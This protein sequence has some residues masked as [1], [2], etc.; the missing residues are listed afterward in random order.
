[1][2]NERKILESFALL[3]CKY[4]IHRLLGNDDSDSSFY[5][6]GMYLLDRPLLSYHY[7]SSYRILS[8]KEPDVCGSCY[9]Y[10]GH[11]YGGRYRMGCHMCYDEDLADKRLFSFIRLAGFDVRQGQNYLIGIIHKYLQ[12]EDM[13]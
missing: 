5:D 2:A 7:L 1:M 3:I 9:T 10:F 12:G 4:D 11:T 6:S 8:S 13:S